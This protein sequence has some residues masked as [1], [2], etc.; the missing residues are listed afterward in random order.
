MSNEELEALQKE[1]IAEVLEVYPAKAVADAFD[2]L[3]KS[4]QLGKL[5]VAI[6]GGFD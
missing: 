4:S 5:V 2:T 3:E 6:K 1:A